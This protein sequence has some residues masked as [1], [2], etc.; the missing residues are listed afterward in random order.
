MWGLFVA[1]FCIA[2]NGF[3]VAAEFAVVKVRATQLRA[4][5][6]SGDKKAMVAITIVGRLDRYLSVT[7]FGITLASLG[8]GWIGE[9]ALSTMLDRLGV[10]L[11]GAPA[12]RTLHLAIDVVAFGIL[13]FGHVLLGELVPKLIAIQRSEATA[14]ASAIPLRLI[15]V[16]FLPFL[17]LLERASRLVLRAMGMSA[18]ATSV[19]GRFSQDEILAIL[20]ATAVR[21]PHGKST[22]ELFERVMRFSQ[23]AARH[24]MVP[25]V[26]VVSLPLQTSGQDAHDFVRTHQFSRIVLTNGRSLDDVAGYLYAKDFLLHPAADKLSDMAQLRRDILF[27]PEVQSGVDVLREMQRKQVPIAVVVDEYGG[28]SGILTMEDLLEEIVGE[29]RDEFDEEPQK[30]LKV[31]GTEG[32]WEV[33][34]RATM[35][36]LRTIGVQI[37]D[38][39]LGEPVGAFV[40]ELLGRL[41]RAG[42]KVELARGATAEVTAISRRRVTRV[43]VKLKQEPEI[44]DS[45]THAGE[46]G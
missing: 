40:V 18:D 32:V 30:V 15:Y 8:L 6:R 1:V 45:A 26:D 22:A 9:P 4:R 31:P 14:M 34:G 16:T 7:Q 42:D 17:W 36:E 21:S 37:P 27:V 29:I 20:A 43:R 2:L 41:P 13:T 44:M 33:D 10:S 35:E 19:E 11:T 24:S 46:S 3:F 23:R 28:T 38:A 25:R 5:A 12:T 39:E